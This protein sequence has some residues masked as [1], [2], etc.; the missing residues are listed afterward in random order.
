MESMSMIEWIRAVASSVSLSKE[1]RAEED[2]YFVMAYADTA[3]RR[4]N[5][6]VT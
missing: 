4:K 5:S 3:L 6:L 2:K 1:P